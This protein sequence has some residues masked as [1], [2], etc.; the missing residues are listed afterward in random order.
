MLTSLYA[1]SLL[2]TKLREGAMP[3]EEAPSTPHTN[4]RPT[5]GPTS[6][7]TKGSRPVVWSELDPPLSPHYRAAP[8]ASGRA[9]R[10]PRGRSARRSPGTQHR[11]VLFEGPDSGRS[12]P[13]RSGTVRLRGHGRMAGLSL[14]RARARRWTGTSC[15]VRPQMIREARRVTSCIRG[16]SVGGSRGSSSAST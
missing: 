8:C 16:R 14:S 3:P 9:A 10:S 2:I 15:Q 12:G 5:S 13:D 7:L 1:P 4:V 6:R 11:N